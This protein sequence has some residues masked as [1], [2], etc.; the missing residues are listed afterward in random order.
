[1]SKPSQDLAGHFRI[2]VEK[3]KMAK[4]RSRIICF[5]LDGT[6]IDSN[7]AHAVSF[8][9]AF[10]KNNLP[11][12][13]FEKIIAKF[14][15]PAEDI[16]KIL[17]PQLS[18]RKLHQ[19]VA[20]KRI[21]LVERTWKL[22][23]P[24]PGVAEAVKK[25]SKKFKLVIYTHSTMDEITVMMRAAKLDKKLFFK[26]LDSNDMHKKPDPD[27]ID[28]VEEKADGKV[29]WIVGDTTYDIETGNNA[30]VQTIAVLTGVH[31]A[32]ILQKEK[33]TII[34]QSVAMLPEYFEGEL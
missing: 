22:T 10:E 30:N 16:V 12:Q 19:V 17:F 2:V 20:D 26:I 34:L 23:K 4:E 15:P 33:P 13:R 32:G 18:E 7:E 25:L 5:D 9:L 31:S 8:N 11:Q 14:G 6:L 27:I 3:A 24:L 1:M 28:A 21:F 29:E